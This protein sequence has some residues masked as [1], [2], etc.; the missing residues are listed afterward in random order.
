MKCEYCN[1][2][3]NIFKNNPKYR[4]GR[5]NLYCPACNGTGEIQTNEEWFCRLSTQEKAKALHKLHWEM[6]NHFE[7]HPD[8]EDY[9]EEYCLCWLKAVH[10]D[11]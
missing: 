6:Q 10:R 8:E 9:V 5:I 4:Q 2:T 7:Y 1:G 11:D 3:G